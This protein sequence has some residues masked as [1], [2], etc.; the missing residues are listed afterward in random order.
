MV[1][2]PR[3]RRRGATYSLGGANSVLGVAS[4]GLDDGQLR[5][6]GGVNCL[7]GGTKISGGLLS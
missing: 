1:G 5:S 2:G 7:G 3:H 4:S 6:E